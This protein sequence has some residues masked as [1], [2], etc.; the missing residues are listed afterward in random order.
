MISARPAACPADDR[1]VGE[2]NADR[3][4]LFLVLAKKLVLA[5]MLGVVAYVG[6]EMF[7]YFPP[8]WTKS[9]AFLAVFLGARFPRMAVLL[10]MLVLG[11]PVLYESMPLGVLYMI[12]CGMFILMFWWFDFFVEAYLLVASTP[13]WASLELMGVPLP[14]YFLP[15]FMGGV[16]AR[17]AWASIIPGIA[18]IGACV[19]GL[20]IGAGN[21]GPLLIG[22]IPKFPVP[23]NLTPPANPLAL[24][25][26]GERIWSPQ[27]GAL[28]HPEKV[29]A[30]AGKLAS[31]FGIDPYMIIQTG[32]WMIAGYFT[33][34]FFSMRSL[35]GDLL[36]CGGGIAA[37]IASPLAINLL[38]K[39]RELK[40]VSP[41]AYVLPAVLA[42]LLAQL[43]RALRDTQDVAARQYE[44]AMA[45]HAEAEYQHA[46]AV[47]NAQ[48]AQ[49]RAEAEAAGEV[50]EE[51]AAPPPPPPPPKKG[52]SLDNLDL[53]DALKLQVQ[54]E[55]M[56]QKKFS[57][58]C[59]VIDV[60]VAGSVKLKEGQKPET[61]LYSFGQFHS[62]FDKSMEKFGGR[63]MDRAG[64]GIIY[65]FHGPNNSDNALAAAKYSL[66][67]L[68]EFNRTRNKLGKDFVVRLGVN[69]GMI[70]K[71]EKTEKGMFFSK[72]ID[73]AGHLQKA[74]PP[75]AVLVSEDTFK[76]LEN[77][78]G[79]VQFVHLAKDDIWAYT[80][81]E[82][83]RK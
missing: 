4:Y 42:F 59:S 79:L 36:A 49:A 1:D 55:E 74:A 82:F 56:M 62:F 6:L 18:C 64:D 45:D 50:W 48:V 9:F 68:E 54:L 43:E 83:A 67:H 81:E 57:Q 41:L 14:L 77:N 17:G 58:E 32:L 72:V 78:S 37:A 69:T 10:N 35:Q 75:N 51:V 71:D 38:F 52:L 15:I 26:I 5:L 3:R 40:D 73:I 46:L 80:L 44:K 2:E 25:W 22:Y 63:L 16:W 61:I 21:I 7:A 24:G 11:I 20:A 23:N 76:R 33:G 28:N 47:Y 27:Y 65:S 60:D 53:Q 8:W 31:G 70:I 34:K 30:Y 29:V 19:T 12:A 66:R 13:M 39:G